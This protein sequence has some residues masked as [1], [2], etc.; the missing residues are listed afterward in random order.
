MRKQGGRLCSSFA[1]STSLLLC[2]GRSLI[3]A[4][5]RCM[6]MLRET[7]AD[8]CMDWGGGSAMMSLVLSPRD[9]NHYRRQ[10]TVEANPSDKASNLRECVSVNIATNSPTKSMREWV[11]P[12][13]RTRIA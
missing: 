12:P 10:N 8:C 3:L 4:I 11:L 9:P 7:L 2:R 13:C 5:C 1:I 6:R